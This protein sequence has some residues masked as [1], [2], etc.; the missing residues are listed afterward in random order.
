LP[1]RVAEVTAYADTARRE[2]TQSLDAA[3]TALNLAALIASDCGLSDLA[4]EL[5]RTHI[6][7]YCAVDRPLTSVETLQLLGPVANLARLRLRA[8]DGDQAITLLEGLLNAVRTRTDLIVDGRTLP[9]ARVAAGGDDR[10]RMVQWAWMQL[11]TDGTKAL[12]LAGR[13]KAAARLAQ[14]HKGIGNHLLEGRQVAIVASLLGGDADGARETL[15]RS[16][17]SE[18]WERQV[19]ACLAALCAP[20]GAEREAVNAMATEYR[21]RALTTEHADYRARLGVTI[22]ALARAANPELADEVLRHAAS[23]AATARDGYAAREVLRHPGIRSALGDM[24][25]ERL[26]HIVD[27]SGLVAGRLNGHTLASLQQAATY[28]KESLVCSLA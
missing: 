24:Y 8:H 25:R 13:W 10:R 16:V 23:E 1:E 6:D 27:G 20:S 14:T 19:A 11:L 26:A 15:A 28:A 17:V 21:A 22:A 5:C 2:P 7:A 12:A 3:A 18:P 9:L 4:T